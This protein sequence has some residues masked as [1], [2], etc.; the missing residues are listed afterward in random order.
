MAPKKYLNKQLEELKTEN[1]KREALLQAKK[2]RETS[3][4][5]SG[6]KLE[7][8][9]GKT[10]PNSIPRTPRHPKLEKRNN[11]KSASPKD[12]ILN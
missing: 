1:K 9:T 8:E 4:Q 6:E 7:Q 10:K 12:P 3:V 2:D 5:D 11:M